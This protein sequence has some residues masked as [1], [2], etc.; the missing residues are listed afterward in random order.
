MNSIDF[1]GEKVRYD[2]ETNML[3]MTDML[4]IGNRFRLERGLRQINTTQWLNTQTNKSFIQDLK[5]H[6]AHVIRTEGKRHTWVHP[7]LFIELGRAIHPEFKI[8][9]YDWVI[10]D[11]TAEAILSRCNDNVIK[12]ENI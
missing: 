3:S 1:Y 5:K 6:F 10:C 11:E 2:I 9:V 4:Y 7:Y 12:V 8:I